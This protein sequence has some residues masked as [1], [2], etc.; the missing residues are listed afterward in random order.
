[1]IYTLSGAGALRAYPR[2]CFA[3]A[4]HQFKFMSAIGTSV[5]VSWQFRSPSGPCLLFKSHWQKLDQK[6]DAN[7]ANLPVTYLAV[8]SNGVNMTRRETL[9]RSAPHRFYHLL[10]LSF[11]V[12]GW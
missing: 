7:L 1:M 5:V 3:E 2:T 12:S 6:S 9:P 8:N 11:N 4:L 10:C